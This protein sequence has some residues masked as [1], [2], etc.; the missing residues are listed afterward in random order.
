[1][2]LFFV[3]FLHKK[4]YNLN[5]K[6]EEIIKNIKDKEDKIL[7]SKVLECAEK[8]YMKDI[9]NYTNFLDPRQLNLCEEILQKEKIKYIKVNPYED[10]DK[11]ILLFLPTYLK[12]D[13]VDLNDIYG[14]IKI[15]LKST[16]ILKHKD[17][18][19]AIYNLG[20]SNEN[21]GD[22]VV[23]EN[24]AYI[25]C[26]LKVLDFFLFNITKV[27]RFEVKVEKEDV[28]SLVNLEKKYEIKNI[29]VKSPRID[30]V[31]SELANISRNKITEKINLGEV[32]LNYK[33]E[34]F[35]STNIKEGDILAVRKVGKFKIN[36]FI[37]YT[38]KNNLQIE[39]KKYID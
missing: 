30:L 10:A 31:V 4:L 27:G 13:M 32:V 37:G 17:Y 7:V 29:T 36:K 19:G 35:K 24:K 25:F 5:M 16:Q 15:S 18:M 39:V 12:Y 33:E 8:S 21:I 14:A 22:I 11:C 9:I 6:K 20:I 2:H 1:M 26:T 38:R 3:A 34:Y 23:L 28:N